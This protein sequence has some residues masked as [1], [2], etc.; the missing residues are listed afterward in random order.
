MDGA[1][2]IA[3]VVGSVD[4]HFAQFPASL[5][6][7]PRTQF[8]NPDI[9][10]GMPQEEIQPL[11][12]MVEERIASYVERR[13][14]FPTK[15]I[16]FRD[17]LSEAQLDMCRNNELPRIRQ[18]IATARTKA[19][20]PPAPQVLLICTIKRHHT[21]LFRTNRQRDDERFFPHGN[22]LPGCLVQSDVTF[23][24]D[25]DFFL[26]SHEALQGTAKPCHYVVLANDNNESLEDIA[27]MVGPTTVSTQASSC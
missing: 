13:E 2:S 12:T 20:N 11:H 7:N 17:G 22:P 23:G 25:K 24:E 3:A 6:M 4:R 16:F 1:P 14:T 18:G 26:I 21:R 8:P 19:G 15:I 9:P 10:H 5:K 27:A